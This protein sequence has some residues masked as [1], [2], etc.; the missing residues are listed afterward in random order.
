MSDTPNRNANA[1]DIRILEIDGIK[2]K[3]TADDFFE[4]HWK[5]GYSGYPGS[6][7]HHMNYKKQS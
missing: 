3:E 1:L 5:L 7:H 4:K 2:Y 6:N